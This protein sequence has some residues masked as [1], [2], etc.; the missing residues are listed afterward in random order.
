MES[1]SNCTT[2]RPKGPRMKRRLA[3]VCVAVL[4]LPGCG[5]T[6]YPT[7]YILNLPAAARSVAP[8]PYIRGPLTL[9]EFQC[10]RYLCEGRIVYRPSL[11]EIGFYEFH[12]WAMNPR[13]MITRSLAD[14]I[15]SESLFH[16]VTLQ[17]VGA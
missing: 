12:R 8:P 5:P 11:E 2:G 15:R 1:H 6:R 13:E 7:H 9:H 16:S 14:S 3:F 10:P 4:S 17:Q